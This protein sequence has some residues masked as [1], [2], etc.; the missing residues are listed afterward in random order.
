[1]PGCGNWSSSWW[2]SRAPR[3]APPFSRP[4]GCT[5]AERLLPMESEIGVV[6]R[7]LPTPLPPSPCTPCRLG[8]GAGN[9][10]S[11]VLQK[12]LPAS[13]ALGDRAKDGKD[14][15]D[16]H[17]RVARQDAVASGRAT[18]AQSRPV[19]VVRKTAGHVCCSELNQRF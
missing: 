6:E 3:P 13:E 15:S 8:A 4:H 7:A 16:R 9:A 11:G 19:C 5:L 17:S 14:L 18:Q 1:M 2:V 10:G 12:A